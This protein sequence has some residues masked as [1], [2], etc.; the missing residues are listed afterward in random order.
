[1]NNDG[2]I[3]AGAIVTLQVDGVPLQARR[4]QTVAAAMLAA[5]RRVLRRTRFKGRP[6]GLFCAMGVCFD[7]VMT[8]DGRNGVRACMTPV[9][10]GMQVVTAT[11]LKPGVA[12]R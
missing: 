3:H 6:R 2:K 10:D 11:E 5:G 8:V 9:E 12:A 1:M 7:C 4:G